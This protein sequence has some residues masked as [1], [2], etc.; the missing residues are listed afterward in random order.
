MSQSQTIE[1]TLSVNT[2]ITSNDI[3]KL[4]MAIIRCLNIAQRLTGDENLQKGIQVIQ[5][6]IMTLRTL[7]MAY[8]ALQIARMSAGDPIAWLTAGTMVASAGATI[9]DS[10][11]GA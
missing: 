9:Y 10:I 8:N 3:R 1:Y 11:T 4:E 7:Q 6:T 5:K 2:E